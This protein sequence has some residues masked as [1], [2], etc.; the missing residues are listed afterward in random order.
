MSGSLKYKLSVLLASLMLVILMFWLYVSL[1]KA[2]ERREEIRESYLGRQVVL[3]ED[4]LIVTHYHRRGGLTL[5]N[6]VVM[7]VSLFE[8]LNRKN[9]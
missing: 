5:S 6:G 7:H 3:M 2:E 9:Q 4:T 1:D 8:R